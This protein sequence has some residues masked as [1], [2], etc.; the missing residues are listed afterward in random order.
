M[1]MDA[2]AGIGASLLSDLEVAALAIVQFRRD[3]VVERS[4][5]KFR[6]AA[7]L[8]R[9]GKEGENSSYNTDCTDFT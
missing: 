1:G 9:P 2:M 8:F 6:A 7:I 5:N 3:V 4:S